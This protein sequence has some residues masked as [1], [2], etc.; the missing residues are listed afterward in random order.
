MACSSWALRKPPLATP[1]PRQQRAW[2]QR[3]MRPTARQ[4]CPPGL[5]Q[6]C[7]LLAAAA[8]AVGPDNRPRTWPKSRRSSR[9]LIWCQL[10]MSWQARPALLI[11]LL[12]TWSVGWYTWC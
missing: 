11:M 5:E 10:R 9:C 3:R 1:P 12:G 4:Q 8:Q 6:G 7:H 2:H